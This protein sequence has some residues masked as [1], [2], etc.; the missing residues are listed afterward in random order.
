MQQVLDHQ[1]HDRRDLNHLLA[2]RIWILSRK[3]RAATAAGIRMVFHHLIKPLNRQQLWPRP[4]MARLATACAATAFA[5]I[6][7]LEPRAVTGGRSE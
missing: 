5:A 4:G 7:R 3:Q 2:Q 1:R 6:R